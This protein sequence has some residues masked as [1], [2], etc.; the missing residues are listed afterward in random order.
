MI[1]RPPRSTLF[2]YTTLFRSR[3]VRRRRA[4][5]VG[6]RDAG[7]RRAAGR[8]VPGGGTGTRRDD[9]LPER[10]VGPHG[11]AAGLGAGDSGASPRR[12]G[13][14]LARGPSA[15]RFGAVGD[16]HGDQR[17]AHPDAADAL[18]GAGAA[19]RTPA[20]VRRRSAVGGWA[21]TTTPLSMGVRSEEHTS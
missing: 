16:E 21:E 18:R 6:G 20:A 13:E 15:I 19:A 9:W 11:G 4:V 1:R 7:P 2:P 17:P 14:D 8:G 5:R 10:A 12:C 3:D